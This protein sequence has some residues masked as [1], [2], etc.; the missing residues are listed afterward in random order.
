MFEGSKYLERIHDLTREA[1]NA[2]ME[3]YH[4]KYRVSEKKD[5]S[6]VTDA[7]LKCEEILIEELSHTD[8]GII[9]EETGLIEGRE[10]DAFWVVDPLDGT[11]DFI[12]QTGEFSIMVGLL[13]EGNPVLGVV[14]A[15][16]LDKLWYATKDSGAHVVQ[17]GQEK[18]I[19]VNDKKSLHDFKVIASR[20]HFSLEDQAIVNQ[21]GINR[22]A[23]MGSL[24]M[25][26]CSIAEGKADLTFYTTDRLGIWDCCAPQAILEEAGGRIMD[27]YG[28]HPSYDLQGQRM[29]GGIVGIGSKAEPVSK[30]I[31]H[32]LE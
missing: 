30:Q 21:L 3:F 19:N 1:G 27:T 7:D 14:Y 24:G 15:P 32:A 16:V 22:V 17:N 10:D 2:S 9:S 29:E 31:I 23:R 20:N 5:N 8:Y 25:K 11:Q 26:F 13:H 12:D 4:R 18:Q 6:P 28:N